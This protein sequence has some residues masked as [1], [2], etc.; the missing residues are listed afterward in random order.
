[1]LALTLIFG[2]IVGFSLGLTGG[3]GSIFAVPLLVYG[4]A[5]AP[6]QAMGM[7][8]AVVGSIALIGAIQRWRRGEIDLLAGGIFAAG[9]VGGAPVGT[10]IRLQLADALLMALFATLMLVIALRMWHT[11][12]RK[13]A[14]AAVV[15]A[16]PDASAAESV[17]L[18][19]R[20]VP[21]MVIVGFLT[22][23]LAG[24]FGV[25]GGFIIV[26]GLV[27]FTTMDIR[28]AVATSLLVIAI[29]SAAGV[30]SYL[31]VSGTLPPSMTVMFILAGII[32]VTLG[33]DIS[34]RLSII[35]LQKTFAVAIVLVGVFILLRNT[36]LH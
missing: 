4:L 28:K 8:L 34:R 14:Q 23:V 24:L 21:V 35:M 31:A 26:P 15:R 9:G 27:M 29:I 30:V 11:A 12:T 33:A 22:G 17:P 36:L 19:T 25:G 10:W 6:Q 7:S 5:I 20:S 13:P 1:M 18:S 3:G 2:L 32:G 16:A